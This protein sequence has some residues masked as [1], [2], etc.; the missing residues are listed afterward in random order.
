MVPAVDAVAVTVAVSEILCETLLA[1]S[2]AN[3]VIVA[4]P[5]VVVL[6]VWTVSVA[7][8][9]PPVME[10]LSKLATIPARDE[11]ALRE[12]VP[13]KPFTACT[14]TTKVPEAPATMDCEVG[15][16]V[17]ENSELLPPLPLE[18]PTTRRGEITQPLATSNSSVKKNAD[19]RMHVPFSAR[20][21]AIGGRF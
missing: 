11:E 9:E 1:V 7:V 14:V 19:L 17:T 8:P 15:L 16:A 5:G 21:K 10:V 20:R 4:V 2:D 12:T 18:P 6:L 13:V 3:T